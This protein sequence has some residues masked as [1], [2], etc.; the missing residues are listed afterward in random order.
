MAVRRLT[1][2]EPTATNGSTPATTDVPVSIATD[3]SPRSTAPVAN[4]K[5]MADGDLVLRNYADY[6][7][8][9][10][11]MTVWGNPYE[12]KQFILELSQLTGKGGARTDIE[13]FDRVIDLPSRHDYYH[14]YM[15]G[16]NF[17]YQFGLP[18]IEE[19]WVSLVAWCNAA[20]YTVLIYTAD[21]VL[22][23]L[24]CCYFY[25]EYDDNLILAI[26]EF[27]NSSIKLGVDD[28]FM[29]TR[30]ANFFHYPLADRVDDEH[31]LVILSNTLSRDLNT[32]EHTTLKG[33]SKNNRIFAQHFK[34]GKLVNGYL[35]LTN[36]DEVETRA[37]ASVIG[38][39]YHR[40]G[41]LRTY[42]SV[43]DKANKYLL[44]LYDTYLMY[45]NP[46]KKQIHYRDDI[47]IY[48]VKFDSAYQSMTDLS[49]PETVTRLD[50]AEVLDSVY[51]NRHYEDSLRMVT[52][53]SY[54]LPVEYINNTIQRLDHQM[55]LND[56]YV[57]VIVRDSGYKRRLGPERNLVYRL[58]QLPY[59]DKIDAMVSTESTIENW[60]A[61]VLEQSSYNFLMRAYREELTADKVI[62]A[63]GYHLTAMVLA[64]P[65]V[66]ASK[67]NVNDTDVR[68]Y[69]TLPV[70]CADRCTVY[71]YDEHGILL[72]YYHHMDGFSYSPVNDATVFIEAIV[73]LGSNRPTLY[74]NPDSVTLDKLINYRFYRA[75]VK[76]SGEFVSSHV[77][78]TATMGIDDVP[79]GYPVRLDKENDTKHWV[80]IG[81][82]RFLAGKVKTDPT[83]TGYYRFTL[84]FGPRHEPLIVPY[85][86]IHVW[87]EGVALVEGI[88]FI[89]DFPHVM[90]TSTEFFKRVTDKVAGDSVTFTYRA[91]GHPDK[92]GVRQ[93]P[94][95]TGFI[96][97]GKLSLDNDSTIHSNK[98]NRFIVGGGV[99]HPSAFVF[100]IQGDAEVNV[101]NGTPYSIDSH[102]IAL[103]GFAGNKQVH[104]GYDAEK[105]LEIAVDAY[106]GVNK[107]ARTDLREITPVKRKYRL[108]SPF[109]AALTEHLL[110][111]KE[112]YL[113]FDYRDKVKLD[114]AV[115]PLLH[116]LNSDPAYLG[117]DKD[118]VT[119][120]PTCRYQQSG[121]PVEIHHRLYAILEHAI[122]QYLVH[123]VGLTDWFKVKRTRAR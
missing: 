6:L 41:D 98:V 116:L 17:P 77:D 95:E 74:H 104:E 14:L 89:V 70:G 69:F 62:D 84:N 96:Y 66:A 118:F 34:N 28:I 83:K 2:A 43:L 114:R 8:N 36:S 97:E 60:K 120:Y 59:L 115:R 75:D 100:N 25:K 24:H 68:R 18:D 51:Y 103:R 64:N 1:S 78:V 121:E 88:D 79:S 37:D 26:K 117:Y 19:R 73:G 11:M 32:L 10:A 65:N 106:L 27:S 85:Q 109:I 119:V 61:R 107:P 110:A 15:I 105:A 16:G 55:E 102:Y 22:V 46:D 71:E 99:Y 92:T 13:L 87:A 54:G 63:Y 29:H 7:T 33:T 67:L 31:K 86:K 56:W 94:K 30:K 48:L 42:Q 5:E 82:D 39:Q 93:P 53:Q 23:P 108:Y 91:L 80:V 20:K 112:H 49:T 90:I 45:P 58:E 40:V 101:P 9:H 57:K 113:D 44:Y 12:D 50:N 52:H 111:N 81:D 4:L 38:Y 3:I 72:G 35:N 47:E 122:K 76:P 123:P 21:G